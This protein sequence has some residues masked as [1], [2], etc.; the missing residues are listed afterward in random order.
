M[1]K[2]KYTLS[3]R[4]KEMVE[5]QLEHYHED[6]R[7][8]EKSKADLIPSPVAK[9]SAEGGGSSATNR[10]TENVVMDIITN[11]HIKHLENSCNAIHRVVEGLA[12]ED[13]KLV[14]LVYWRREY[15]VEGAGQIVGLSKSSAYRHV[16]DILTDIA[17][18]LGYVSK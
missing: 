11:Q 10:G 8:L 3:P 6:R 15:T 16:N 14:E 17:Q 5:W 4:I 12:P 2:Y 18:E 7:Q 1:Q 9:L 13:I